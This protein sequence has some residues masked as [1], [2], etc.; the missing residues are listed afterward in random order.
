MHIIIRF[1]LTFTILLQ[2]RNIY[3]VV[4][5]FRGAIIT[6]VLAVDPICTSFC[7]QSNLLS[8]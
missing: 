2:I 4:I 6:I 3:Y 7:A 8:N 1:T 5:L